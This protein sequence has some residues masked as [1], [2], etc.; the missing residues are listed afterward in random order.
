MQEYLKRHAKALELDK[1]LKLLAEQTSCDA[2]AQA[3]LELEPSPRDAERLLQ[4]TD[5]AFVLMARFGSPSFGGLTDVT[6]S[7]RRAEA[8][9]MLTM[10]EL[11]HRWATRA[12]TGSG[13]L[14]GGGSR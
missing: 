6:N 3:A 10:A 13:V 12:S 8:G 4:E 11:A 5:D 2:A 14:V 9:G 7:L 1:I